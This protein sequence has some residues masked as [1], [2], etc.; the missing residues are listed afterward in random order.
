[1]EYGEPQPCG[2]QRT[3][4]YASFD[5]Y[6]HTAKHYLLTGRRECPECGCKEH[7]K[8]DIDVSCAHCGLLLE[9]TTNIMGWTERDVVVNNKNKY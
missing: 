8:T 3:H 9:S 4:N 5:D 2:I 1:M 6:Y 7:Y